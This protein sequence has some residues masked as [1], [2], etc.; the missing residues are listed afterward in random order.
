M[1]SGF[2]CRRRSTLV[3]RSVD[4]SDILSRDHSLTK[5]RSSIFT[6][7]PWP[8]LKR[9]FGRRSALF[10]HVHPILASNADAGERNVLKIT[11]TETP[12]E[13]RWVLQGR[14][15]GP[16]VSELSAIWR[17][18]TRTRKG[19]TCVVYLN[20]VTFID[21]DAE[22]LLC[23]MSREGAQFIANSSYI[24]HVLEGLKIRCKRGLS[25]VIAS[26]F[27]A[28]LNSPIVSSHQRE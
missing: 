12:T 17:T 26:L 28:L 8:R 5:R 18:A 13:A 7:L 25:E 21:K 3:E 23:A 9:V 2:K 16:W 1:V 24:K 20:D 27:E 22:E 4:S 15:F 11:I 6:Q 14:L 19:R 10:P